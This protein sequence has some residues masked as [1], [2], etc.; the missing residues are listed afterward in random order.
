MREEVLKTP[1]VTHYFTEESNFLEQTWT[2]KIDMDVEDFKT[3]MLEYV[4][5]YE[6]LT[7]KKVLVDSRLMAYAVTPDVQDWLNERIMPTVMQNV[8]Q[9]AF[10]LSD[11]LFEEMSIR[12]AI[13]DSKVAEQIVQFFNDEE[14]A[15]T[16]LG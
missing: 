11:D 5:L 16:W 10:I 12:Q 6:N 1:F 15:K 9:L 7:V 3:N 14:K 8:R 13:D 4:G 2:N